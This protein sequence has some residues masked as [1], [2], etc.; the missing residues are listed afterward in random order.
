MKKNVEVQKEI[1][2][3]CSGNGTERPKTRPNFHRG[4]LILILNAGNDSFVENGLL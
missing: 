3:F 4:K 1:A 2:Y